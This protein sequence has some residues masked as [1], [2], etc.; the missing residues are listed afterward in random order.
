MNRFFFSLAASCSVLAVCQSACFGESKG[1]KGAVRAPSHNSHAPKRTPAHAHSS[2]AVSHPKS[3]PAHRVPSAGHAHAP[4]AA[5]SKAGNSHRAPTLGHAHA[6]KTAQ[7]NANHAH[8]TPVVGHAHPVAETHPHAG[9]LHL[10]RTPVVVAGSLDFS[11]PA[12]PARILPATVVWNERSAVTLSALPGTVLSA[13]DIAIVGD[14]DSESAPA[15]LRTYAERILEVANET[16]ET[17]TVHVQYRSAKNGG[18]TW[19]PADPSSSKE[20]VAFKLEPGQRTQISYEDAV[21]RASKVR[22]WADGSSGGRWNQYQSR[23]L[24]LVPETNDVGQHL[25]QAV[26]MET[27]TFAIR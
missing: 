18:F 21:V 7:P 12:Y 19:A 22:I 27:Q 1:G 20:A 9:H 3:S 13:P 5:P 10:T 17:V 2:P 15:Q 16:K 26:E 24:W 23:D 11:V 4:A 25:Y 14:N 6:P 8:R